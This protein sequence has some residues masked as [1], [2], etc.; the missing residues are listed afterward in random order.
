MI[1]KISQSMVRFA[2]TSLGLEGSPSDPVEDWCRK[3]V[4]AT[5]RTHLTRLT[6][7]EKFSN[8][9]RIAYGE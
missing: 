8:P 2:E 4:E 6:K 5:T 7:L 3:T 9:S 1:E